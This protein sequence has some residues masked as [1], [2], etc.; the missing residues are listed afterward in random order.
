MHISSSSSPFYRALGIEF[1]SD[2]SLTSNQIE[3]SDVDKLG[4]SNM[5]SILQR[6]IIIPD[7]NGCIQVAACCWFDGEQVWLDLPELGRL[8]ISSDEIAYDLNPEADLN[9][10]QVYLQGYA[11]G[12]QALLRHQLV[13]H[14][15]TVSRNGK[16][17]VICG[18]SGVGKSTLATALLAKGF[19]LVSDDIT[20]IN[21]DGLVQPGFNDI[22]VWRDAVDELALPSKQLQQMRAGLEKYYYRPDR[23]TQQP[24]PI[25]AVYVLDVDSRVEAELNAVQGVGKFVQ[26]RAHTYC[27]FLLS[28]LRLDSYY[29]KHSVALLGNTPLINVNRKRQR[30]TAGI[31]TPL[32]DAIE[33]D[34]QGRGV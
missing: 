18:Y 7:S 26:L 5:L 20:V 24:V 27:H 14:A 16:A 34:A 11:F 32:V 10:F 17:I 4:Y 25:A 2:I 31:L 33:Q 9:L 1:R 13:L 21:A 29:F 15:T 30:F 8:Q 19:S 6:P 28:P 12:V 3:D 23:V 22:K